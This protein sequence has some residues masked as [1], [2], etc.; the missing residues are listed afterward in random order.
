MGLHVST[1]SG[2][3]IWLAAPAHLPPRAQ[4]GGH[5]DAQGLGDACAPLGQQAW[6]NHSGA[7]CLQVQ[8]RVILAEGN[9]PNL[10]M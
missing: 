9:V 3:P 8:S 1:L 4:D 6:R 7:R 10:P 5:V 2:C